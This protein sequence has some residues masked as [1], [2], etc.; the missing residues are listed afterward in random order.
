MNI[1]ESLQLL[2]STKSWIA[3]AIEYNDVVVGDIPFYEYAEKIRMIAV[4][5]WNRPL[6]WIEMPEILENEQKFA[7]LFAVFPMGDNLCALTVSGN[8]TV[9]W[10]DGVV[11][12]Y[13]S[14]E[15][16][17]HAY[18]GNSPNFYDTMCSRGFY[19][20]MVIVTPQAGY[21]ITS[22]N[23][24]VRHPLNSASQTPLAP[25]L[26]LKISLDFCTFITISASIKYVMMSLLENVQL[27][28]V[29]RL[30]S[31]SSMFSGCYSLKSVDLSGISSNAV[32]I[33]SLA[34]A[35]CFSLQTVDLSVILD[36]NTVTSMSSMFYNCYALKSV[37]L[38]ALSTENVTDMSRMSS[39]CALPVI[40]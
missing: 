21:D 9:D 3:S 20:A 5:K 14:G 24:N 32:T 31:M 33:M 28:A 4:P 36:T 17:S 18:D 1:S 23:L 40:G 8:Y 11:Q 38:S 2:N 12:N 13:A 37:N 30:G 39:S 15:T 35:N 26:D 34:F 7:G 10:G 19:Q 29:L 6:D 25:W 22:F 16:A 27:Q